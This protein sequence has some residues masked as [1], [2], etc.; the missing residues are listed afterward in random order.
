[1][2]LTVDNNSRV[3]GMAS[4]LDTESIV[5]GLM[6]SYQTQ[7]DKQN[8]TT[9]KLEWKADAYREINTLIKN[10]RSKSLSV[11]SGTNM[12]SGSAYNNYMV[13]ML[14]ITN[15]VSISASS[16]ASACSMNINSITQ[17]AT[18]GA[19]SRTQITLCVIHIKKR[20]CAIHSKLLQG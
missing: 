3:T 5:K 6:T 13:N 9:T 17:L 14:T 10:F 15:A 7:L 16:S 11:L 12:M 18:V 2:A 4:G 20:F 19:Q 1:M 8:K